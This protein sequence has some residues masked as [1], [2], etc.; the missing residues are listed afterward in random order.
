MCLCYLVGGDL[1]CVNM[2][3]HSQLCGG[4]RRVGMVRGGGVVVG[5]AGVVVGGAGAVVGGAGVMVGGAGVL[6]GSAWTQ[7]TTESCT[8][9]HCRSP[10][11]RTLR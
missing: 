2:V 10:S 1:C 7:H 5:G 3:E 8:T 6:W 4:G 9:S 11:Q